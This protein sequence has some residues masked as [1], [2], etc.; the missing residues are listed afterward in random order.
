MFETTST[1]IYDNKKT[2]NLL[3]LDKLKSP[4]FKSINDL[5]ENVINTIPEIINDINSGMH[6]S[7]LNKKYKQ[8][9]ENESIK[10]V[11][12][13]IIN[14]LLGYYNQDN[15]DLIIVNTFEEYDTETIFVVNYYNK[16]VHVFLHSKSY[17]I[18]KIDYST[19]KTEIHN[20][21]IK[22]N[23][24]ICLIGDISYT[25]N[26]HQYNNDI[27]KIKNICGLDKITFENLIE[28]DVKNK[29]SEIRKIY[30]SAK[31]YIDTRENYSDLNYIKFNIVSENGYGNIKENEKRNIWMIFYDKKSNPKSDYVVRKSIN[32][33]KPND[34]RI[35]FINNY[36]ILKLYSKNT[37]GQFDYGIFGDQVRKFMNNTT[38]SIKKITKKF[39]SNKYDINDL[40]YFLQTISYI[41]F[42]HGKRV[43]WD[44]KNISWDNENSNNK[45]RINST[46]KL[47]S[48]IYN[49]LFVFVDYYEIIENISDINHNILLKDKLN[50]V[51][52]DLLEIF[53]T[54]NTDDDYS[55][56]K[57]YC[58]EQIKNRYM[59]DYFNLENYR[60]GIF[61][62]VHDCTFN[63]INESFKMSY[64]HNLLKEDKSTS[65]IYKSNCKKMRELEQ[66]NKLKIS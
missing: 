53:I 40:H 23:K 64:Y 27:G 9:I 15:N 58:I 42:N 33:Y 65:V 16:T 52:M 66:K 11:N 6:S 32:I 59:N 34:F 8:Y 49:E 41:I 4:Q 10:Y 56:N 61:K 54:L 45:L 2:I 19:V 55:L 20:F 3:L 43:M 31:K 39:K 30:K 57:T 21:L 14:R 62:T 25:I 13:F 17:V 44:M 46:L 1:L 22:L 12:F 28:F 37:S 24:I 60:F 36:E 35:D 38:N 7:T 18:D 26:F 48:D 63:D 5:S 29:V 50:N 47:I 51:E